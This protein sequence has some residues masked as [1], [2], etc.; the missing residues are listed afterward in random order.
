M[1]ITIDVTNEEAG[2]LRD[3]ANMFYLANQAVAAKGENLFRDCD[4]TNSIASVACYKMLNAI[5]EAASDCGLRR[6]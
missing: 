2:A 1:I 5:D 6:T 3:L 4:Y